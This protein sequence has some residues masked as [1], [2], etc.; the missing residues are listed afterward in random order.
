[1]TIRWV[2]REWLFRSPVSRCVHRGRIVTTGLLILVGAHMN[3]LSSQST[4]ALVLAL[5]VTQ[6]GCNEGKD[7]PDVGIDAGEDAAG[8][9]AGEDA[10]V[11][12]ATDTAD[13]AMPLLGCADPSAYDTSAFTRVEIDPF[14]LLDPALSLCAAPVAV[15]GNSPCVPHLVYTPTGDALEPLVVFLP[16][17][18][19][20]PNKHERLLETAAYAGYRTIGLAYDNTSSVQSACEMRSDC[21]DRCRS[22]VREEVA[23]GIDTVPITADAGRDVLFEDGI[24]PRLYRALRHAATL[25]PDYAVYLAPED[26]AGEVDVD[27]ILWDKIIVAGFSQGAG[28]ASYLSRQHE[29]QGLVMF[30]GGADLCTDAAGGEVPAG[31]LTDPDASAGRPKFILYHARGFPQTTLHPGLVATGFGPAAHELDDAVGDVVDLDPPTPASF[32]NH[33]PPPGANEHN[34]MARDESM[35][36]DFAG[37]DHA[38]EANEARLF[39]ATLLRFCHACDDVTCPR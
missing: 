16:G 5:A 10:A 20:E 33:T 19:M 3:S 21:V 17:T 15:N 38:V 22:R 18:N 32:T 8:D 1:M 25:D 26:V 12:A 11:D 6:L 27:D 13:G 14:P 2:A 31:W 35:P 39:E 37:T 4:F 23:T 34:S 9:D 29:V 24:L 30:D 28:M 7:D 36:I